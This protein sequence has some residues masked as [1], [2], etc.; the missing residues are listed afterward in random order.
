MIHA[1]FVP[2]NLLR[3]ESS[4]MLIDFDDAGFGW[5]MFELATALYFHLDTPHFEAIRAAL[6]AGYQSVRPLSDA[7]VQQL[8]L[9]L[10]LRSITYLSWV[11]TRR[12][13]ETARELMP[14]FVERTVEL[15]RQYLA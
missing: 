11:H 8:P 7:Y 5:H 12:E 6:L 13:T 14:M 3:A 1:D 10:L 15:A 9:F 4:L 2:E